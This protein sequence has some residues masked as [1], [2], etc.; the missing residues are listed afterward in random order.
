M[1]FFQ[2]FIIISFLSFCNAQCTWNSL[3]WSCPMS[4]DSPPSVCESFE[5]F[6]ASISLSRTYYAIRIYGSRN[7]TGVYCYEYADQVCK[8]LRY[9]PYSSYWCN[10][11]AWSIGQCGTAVELSTSPEICSCASQYAVSPCGSL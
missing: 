1:F 4:V 8:G 3:G 5:S 10:G 11:M 7:P 2:V 9:G 6:R